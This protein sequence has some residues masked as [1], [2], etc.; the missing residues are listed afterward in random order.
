MPAQTSHFSG[1]ARFEWVRPDFGVNNPNTRAFCYLK[2]R[3]VRAA[4]SHRNPVQP[5][6]HITNGRE[7]DGAKEANGG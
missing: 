3:S 5:S 6:W 2:A 1:V 7:L 4:Q